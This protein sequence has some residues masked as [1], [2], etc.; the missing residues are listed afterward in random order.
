M[1]F[2]Q[3]AGIFVKKVVFIP[4][5]VLTRAFRFIKFGNVPKHLDGKRFAFKTV[6]I[7][8]YSKF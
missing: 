6:I 5:L 8:I 1:F 2:N 4:L 3:I 7:I